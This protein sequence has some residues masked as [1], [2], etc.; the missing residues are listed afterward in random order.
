M[1]DTFPI[2][3]TDTRTA[4]AARV[5]DVGDLPQAVCDL[6]LPTPCPV[7]ALLGGAGGMTPADLNRLRSLLDEALAP[8]AE[9]LNAVIVDGGT[10]AG[11]LRLMGQARAARHFPLVGVVVERLAALPSQP[12]KKNQWTLEAH[13]TH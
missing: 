13:H 7:I 6:G 1:V 12:V 5:H 9:E 8:I 4:L 2:K 11:I 10:D 3:F